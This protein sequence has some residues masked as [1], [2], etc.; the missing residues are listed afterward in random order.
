MLKKN[1]HQQ[2]LCIDN[3]YDIKDEGAISPIKCLGLAAPKA[4]IELIKC[5]AK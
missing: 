2:H 4:V 5:G 3:G 1:F